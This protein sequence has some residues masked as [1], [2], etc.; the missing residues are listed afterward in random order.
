MSQGG[1][2][3]SWDRQVDEFT[4]QRTVSAELEGMKA[5]VRNCTRLLWFIHSFTKKLLKTD[6]VPCTVPSPG[7]RARLTVYGMRK[8][9]ELWIM[10]GFLVRH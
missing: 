7:S 2:Q 5:G 8:I 1:F 4:K 10:P 6:C 9:R 3:R